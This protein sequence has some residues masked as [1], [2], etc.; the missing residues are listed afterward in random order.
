MKYWLQRQMGNFLF[1]WNQKIKIL[2]LNCYFNPDTIAAILVFNEVVELL[3]ILIKYDR[4]LG[5]ECVPCDT[6]W[7]WT[8]DEVEKCGID[9]YYYDGEKRDEHDCTITTNNTN[10]VSYYLN[11]GSLR[12]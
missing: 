5:G 1:W 12:G 7:H 10:N 6:Q 8:C 2:P 3:N 9:L 11:I 4:Q